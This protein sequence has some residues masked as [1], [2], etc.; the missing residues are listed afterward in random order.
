MRIE[1]IFCAG[2]FNHI[3]KADIISFS[4]NI[5]SKASRLNLPPGCQQLLGAYA[6]YE[7]LQKKTLLFLEQR[8]ERFGIQTW[9][10]QRGRSI[11]KVVFTLAFFPHLGLVG[12]RVVYIWW[13]ETAF[14]KPWNDPKNSSLLFLKTLTWGSFQL[15]HGAVWYSHNSTT[16]IVIGSTPHITSCLKLCDC[17]ER[18]VVVTT[19]QASLHV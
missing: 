7:Q 18:L 17:R 9:S 3:S 10:G 12:W 2:E 4:L 14:F 8:S 1:G 6:V 5:C 15:S 13:S 11:T 19:S 16:S